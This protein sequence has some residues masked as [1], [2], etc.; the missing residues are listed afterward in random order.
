MYARKGNSGK[1]R[2]TNKKKSNRWQKRYRCGLYVNAGTE[3]AWIVYFYQ[4]KF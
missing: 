2:S 1:D 3:Q 4:I